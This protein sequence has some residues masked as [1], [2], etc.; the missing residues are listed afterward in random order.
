MCTMDNKINT[1]N[2]TKLNNYNKNIIT[3]TE[4]NFNQHHDFNFC[5][6]LLW[7]LKRESIS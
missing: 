3:P 5:E 2:K 1:N 6:K 7:T 4:Y